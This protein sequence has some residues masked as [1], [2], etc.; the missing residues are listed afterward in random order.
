[1]IKQCVFVTAAGLLGLNPALALDVSRY[2][3]LVEL[4]EI[5]SKEDGY[6]REELE[7]VLSSSKIDEQIIELMDRPYESLPWHR[8]RDLFIKESRI[9]R[10]VQFWQENRAILAA[11]EKEFGV[12]QA[13]LVALLGVETHYGTRLGNR[14]VLDSLVTLSADYP[15]RSKFFTSELRTFLNTSRRENIA[16]NSVLGSYAGA[17]G[18]PQFMP[19]SYEAYS[20]DFNGNGRRDLVNE[21]E[22][23]IGSVGNY[24]KEHGWTRGEAI[25]AL[26]T[27][28]L[29]DAARDLVSKRSKLQHRTGDLAD[30]GV[31]F[32]ARGGSDKAALFS[33]EQK[34]GKD[35]VVGYRNFYAL[36]RYNTSINYAMAVTELS[37]QIARRMGG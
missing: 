5:M 35:H 25:F 10:G 17:I 31:A 9:V 7:A 8:Y 2:P 20:V 37:M 22:D 30:A 34:S 26:V 12:P 27:E 33:L 14:R 32:D 28:D 21:M 1:M 18:I 23:A 4:V 15:R 36:T 6:P 13:I 19:S 29:P 11:V 24:L 16:A 3:V